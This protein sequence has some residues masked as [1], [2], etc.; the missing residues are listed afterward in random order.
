MNHNHT[1][2]HKMQIMVWG[3]WQRMLSASKNL[4]SNFSLKSVYSFCFQRLYLQLEN[5]R[6][7]FNTLTDIKLTVYPVLWYISND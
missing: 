2:L 7:L 4:W 5:F 3:Y 6:V 1:E